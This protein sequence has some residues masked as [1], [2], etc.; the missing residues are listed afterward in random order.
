[1]R[2]ADIPG[3]LARQM[4][5]LAGQAAE[6]CVVAVV[7]R[8][9][10]GKSTFIN[11]LLGSDLAKVGTTETTATINRFV[12]GVPSD[13]ARPVRCHWRNGSVTEE[14]R[15]FLDSLQGNRIET[16]R[17]A[18][19]IRFVEHYCTS[20]ILREASLVDTPGTGAVVDEHQDRTAEFLQL[21]GQLRE[22]H[23]A[24]TRRIGR[25]ADA[26]IYLVGATARA[27]DQAFLEEFHGATGGQSR[28]FNAVGVL[29]K[30]DLQPEL[31]AR[32]AELAA[33]IAAQLKDGL[34]SVVPVAAALQRVVDL[35]EGDPSKRDRAVDLARRLSRED[36]DLLLSMEELFMEHEPDG[37][38][39]P[40][41][42][43]Q[44][45][46]RDFACPWT[47]FVM[48][49]QTA[50]DQGL[51]VVEIMERLGENSG[52]GPLKR[53]LQRHLFARGHILRCF[54]IVTDARRLVD[55]IRFDHIPAIRLR[56]EQ[57]R[58][59]LERLLE[60]IAQSTGDRELGADLEALVR[61]RFDGTKRVRPLED[62]RRD[63]EIDLA[64]LQQALADDNADFEALLEV[65]EHPH[66]FSDEELD[67]T[68]A[69]LGMYGMEP[70][71]R[72]PAGRVEPAYV[73]GRQ[74]FWRD[75]G[76]RAHDPARR[77]VAETVVQRYGR[78]LFD[79]TRAAGSG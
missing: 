1:L 63:L 76:L 58:P 41:R 48:L 56:T 66:A 32:R 35:A 73:R 3:D 28:A 30:V 19:G 55:E 78:I 7:G 77:V 10:A 12:Y 25:E 57:D 79:L 62:L 39:V 52:F 50:S 42:E 45:L 2:G 23:D 5:R 44:A 59:R 69:V 61:E 46:R 27:S 6:P 21:Y 8:V 37:C 29:A 36:L 64:E 74:L 75:A 22:R 67:E 70:D 60:F 24:E 15:A 72:L 33:K 65:E 20:P 40:A 38:R 53:K 47:T 54:R 68:R 17:R 71:K 13:P 9:K 16:L 31:M 51:S 4:E 49:L 11:A 14:T 43:R 18:D 34:N 26:V